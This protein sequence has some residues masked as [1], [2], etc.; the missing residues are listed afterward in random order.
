MKV[1]DHLNWRYATKVFDKEK[2]IPK[3]K[4]DELFE[5][6]RLSPSSFG[7]QPWRFIHVK[8]PETRAKLREAA[9]NQAQ[10]TD[11]SDFLVLCSMQDVGP[12]LVE[13]FVAETAKTRGVDPS[14]MESYKEMM[15]GFVTG[16]TPENLKVWA[17]RQVY[18]ALGTLVTSAAM[19]EID[20]GPMEGFDSAK[21]DEILG[22]R[23]QNLHAE[24]VCA[25]GYRSAD[26]KYAEAKKVRDPKKDLFIEM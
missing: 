13:H 26:D 9:W 17:G 15:M 18:I 7:L 23:A 8:N 10:V 11:A 5:A 12:G 1:I 20:A 24:V 3:E 19:M 16:T 25:L 2:K 21:F 22:L 6:L 4:L 14:T